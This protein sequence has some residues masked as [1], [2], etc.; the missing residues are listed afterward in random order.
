[1]TE[2]VKITLKPIMVEVEAGTSKEMAEEALK[3]LI[4]DAEKML[5]VQS[6]SIE[7]EG[8]LTKETAKAGMIVSFKDES[9]NLMTG[10]ITGINQKTANVTSNQI[11]DYRVGFGGLQISEESF[12]AVRTKKPSFTEWEEGYSGYMKNGKEDFPVVMGKKAGQKVNVYEVG[13]Q[14]RRYKLTPFEIKQFIRE[15]Q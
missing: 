2:K 3:I 11:G 12:E 7:K 4:K 5:V 10:I 1:M 8:S 6:I 14:Y 13:G 15:E 9:R